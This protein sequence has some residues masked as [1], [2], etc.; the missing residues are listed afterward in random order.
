MT[1]QIQE[2]ALGGIPSPQPD[3]GINM[4]FLILFTTFGVLHLETFWRNRKQQKFFIFNAATAGFCFI[5]IIATSLRIGWAYSPDNISLAAA[6]QLFIPIGV[7]ILIVSNLY[8]S[9]RILRAQHP[10]F[11][12]RLFPTYVIP[13]VVLLSILT[14]LL[15]IISTCI[16]F[17]LTTSRA[18]Q[19][20]E[21]AQQY[22]VLLFAIL[23]VI[24]IP[25]LLTSALAKTHPDV[26]DRSE[27]NFGRHSVMMKIIVCLVTATLLS[28]GA[29]FRATISFA[30]QVSVDQPGPWYFSK[31]CFYIFN[32]A[33]EILVVIFW[34][35]VRIDKLFIVPDGAWGP[36]SYAGGFVFAGEPGNEKSTM[37]IY[38]R[39]RGMVYTPQSIDVYSARSSTIPPPSPAR[40]ESWGSATRRYMC[41]SPSP[42]ISPRVE[43]GSTWSGASHTRVDSAWGGDSRTN[44]TATTAK[45][46]LEIQ[47]PPCARCANCGSHEDLNTW[48][49]ITYKAMPEMGFDPR[50]GRW[51]RRQMSL[52]A[53]SE[54]QYSVR[55]YSERHT[56]RP[57]S[58]IYSR[59]SEDASPGS[60]LGNRR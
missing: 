28:T 25:I 1:A 34:M 55:A 31:A 45:D 57:V 2:R 39:D 38:N 9:Q 6:A 35:V 50:S 36:Q 16:G 54:S 49:D 29:L 52:N 58:T 51:V 26:K 56:L 18:Q 5:R 48:T 7:I 19:V 17:H 60:F 23:A 27:D 44:V 8:W 37:T 43:Q 15:L 53:P 13:A 20:A 21:G 11:G 59:M 32:F 4:T 12:W 40:P 22:G 14:I 47:Q 10:N 46:S 24:P 3:V 30:P 41:A 33:L 42:C